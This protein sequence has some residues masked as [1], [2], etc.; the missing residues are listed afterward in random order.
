MKLF[1][2]EPLDFGK[3]LLAHNILCLQ[4]PILIIIAMIVKLTRHDLFLLV[5][6]FGVPKI[7]VSNASA[8]PTSPHHFTAGSL[9]MGCVWIIQQSGKTFA[10]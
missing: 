9:A 1:A 3:F 5:S 8:K 2:Q 6:P 10:L 4:N 7:P